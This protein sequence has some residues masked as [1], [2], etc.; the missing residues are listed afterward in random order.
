MSSLVSHGLV[1][2]YVVVDSAYYFH[3]LF[4][5]LLLFLFGCVLSDDL[6]GYIFHC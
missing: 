2:F 1:Y 5:S 3:F 6:E 4:N